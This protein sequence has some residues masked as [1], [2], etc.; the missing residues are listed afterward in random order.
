MELHR[1]CRPNG[2]TGGRDRRQHRDRLRNGSCTGAR[3]VPTWS[4]R[5]ATCRRLR[6]Q[7]TDQC[8]VLSVLVTTAHSGWTQTDLARNNRIFDQKNG[9]RCTAHASRRDRS[10]SPGRRLLRPRRT[11]PDSRG[12]Q[13]RP[14]GEGRFERRHREAPVERERGTR[15]VP[16]QPP[17]LGSPHERQWATTRP[18]FQRRPQRTAPASLPSRA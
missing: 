5:V 17:G 11:L 3:R 9:R 15:R 1:H 4:G 7:R 14:H 6:P 10:H 18:R 2:A 8:W 13:T 12:A 16:L